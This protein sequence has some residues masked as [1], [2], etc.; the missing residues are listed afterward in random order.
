VGFGK[1]ITSDIWLFPG[2]IRAY[3]SSRAQLLRFCDISSSLD[4]ESATIFLKLRLAL[5]DRLC[6]P[7]R[8]KSVIEICKCQF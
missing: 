8:A 7:R 5:P 1:G 3:L 2:Y 4:Q 6:S